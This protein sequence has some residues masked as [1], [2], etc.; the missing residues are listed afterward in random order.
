M[1]AQ[2]PVQKVSIHKGLGKASQ[3]HAEDLGENNMMGHVG[4]NGSTM[5]ERIKR[6]CI[7]NSG[8]IG[9]NVTQ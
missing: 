3:G 2:K 1:K 8:H 9:E 6:Y 5:P 7:H 4:S